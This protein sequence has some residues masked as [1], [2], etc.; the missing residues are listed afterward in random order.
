MYRDFSDKIQ[1]YRDLPLKRN[2]WCNV[3]R[4]E[5]S[6]PM[7]FIRTR[8]FLWQEGHTAHL[9]EEGAGEEVL[10]IL[11]YYAGVYEELL[12]VPVIKGRKTVN[13]QFP[14]AAYTTT[15]E[16]YIPAT[17]RGC[18]AGTSHCLGQHFAKMYD[19]AVEDPAKPGSKEKIF[20]TQNS[21]GLSTRSLG[22]MFLIHSDDKGAVIPPRVAETQ[23]M[24]IPVGL[25]AKTSEEDK[26]AHFKR[27]HVM[28]ETLKAGSIRA[29]NDI[30]ENYNAGWKMSE[31][32][33][34]GI[35][36]RIEFG[37]KQACLSRC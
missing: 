31:Y 9:T 21:W 4:W 24:I 18:Q 25:T 11:D 28:T 26:N 15:I 6:N 22:L 32:E 7:P 35:P 8:E 36:L 37:K 2:Q 14:G 12:A 27:I 5:F 34:R 17:G 33:L 10:Q 1:S 16:G 19:I 20:V 13:E 29:D 3:V 23:T 30:R